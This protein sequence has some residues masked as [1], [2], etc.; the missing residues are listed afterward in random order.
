M[1]W[2]QFIQDSENDHIYHSELFTLTKRMARADPQKLTFTVPIFEPHPPQYYIRAVSDSW[3]HA[4]ALYTISFH[5]LAL[6]EV[7]VFCLIFFF[8]RLFQ[9]FFFVCPLLPHFPI[10]LALSSIRCS[11]TN[12]W[13]VQ[14]RTTHTELLDLKPLPVSSLGNVTYEALYNFSHFNPIQT[15]VW[16]NID[17][18]GLCLMAFSCIKLYCISYMMLLFWNCR[19][20]TSFITRTTM[21]C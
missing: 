4:E 15:Q 20:F 6:P 5:N 21:F 17:F 14:A 12:M 10:Y 2:Q 1:T 11:H 18:V 13:C 19:Y 9:C 8:Q 3:L 16:F 7:L